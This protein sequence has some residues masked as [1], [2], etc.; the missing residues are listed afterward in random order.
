MNP[1]FL[2]DFIWGIIYIIIQIVLI[3][4]LRLF[5]VQADIFWLFLIYIASV[6]NRTYTIFLTGIL[7]FMYDAMLDTWGLYMFSFTAALFLVHRFIPRIQE[8]KLL[9]PQIALI[10]FAVS[11]VTNGIVAGMTSFVDIYSSDVFFWE[12]LLGN[13]LYTAL[14]GSFLFNFSSATQGNS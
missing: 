14:L 13:S 6:R 10:I 4:H 12:I 3:R 1:L 7:T 2:K 5:D 11:L 8:A 9:T